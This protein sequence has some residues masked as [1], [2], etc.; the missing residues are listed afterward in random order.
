MAV[1]LDPI[2][3]YAAICHDAI[4]HG[5]YGDTQSEVLSTTTYYL[6]P[7]VALSRST[8]I[9]DGRPER[10]VIFIRLDSMA[11]LSWDQLTTAVTTCPAP[12]SETRMDR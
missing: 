3:A 2:A 4:V 6:R 8:R 12:R 7:I 9:Q 1:S 10:F 5:A 11:G